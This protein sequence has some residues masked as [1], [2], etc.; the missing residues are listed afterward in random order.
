MSA[1][2]QICPLL[3]RLPSCRLAWGGSGKSFWVLHLMFANLRDGGIA[4]RMELA[5]LI[6][7][8]ICNDNLEFMWLEIGFYLV[9]A[10][11]ILD[12]CLWLSTYVSLWTHPLHKQ[13]LL[14]PPVKY[15]KFDC[16]ALPLWPHVPSFFPGC[17]NS[18]ELVLLLLFLTNRVCFPVRIVFLKKYYIT[19]HLKSST[20][21]CQCL[22]SKDHEHIHIQ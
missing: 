11:F 8:W 2:C 22:S 17:W 10:N 3:P 9:F 7:S 12:L 14:T 5:S 20:D 21:I 4:G 15:I 18:L 1:T 13:V 16:F 19:S 6:N